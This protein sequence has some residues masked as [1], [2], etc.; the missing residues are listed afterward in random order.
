LN[1]KNDKN[2]KKEK[3]EKKKEEG[4][5]SAVGPTVRFVLPKDEIRVRL[6]GNAI[7]VEI[8]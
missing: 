6:P 4:I 5:E 1:D 3:K 2:D 7:F 8:D